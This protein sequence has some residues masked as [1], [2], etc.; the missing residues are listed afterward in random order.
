MGAAEPSRQG[1]Q[2][3]QRLGPPQPGSKPHMMRRLCHRASH[4]ASSDR[5][6]A[7]PP[8][9]INGVMGGGWALPG[10]AARPANAAASGRGRGPASQPP[11]GHG[12]FRLLPPPLHRAANSRISAGHPRRL[13]GG[14]AGSWARPSRAASPANAT[15]SG[16]RRGPAAQP[17]ARRAIPTALSPQP[18]PSENSCHPPRLPGGGMARAW[19]RPSRAARPANASASGRRRGPTT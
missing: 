18:E 8:R 16:R 15:A 3:R 10:R 19:A 6:S 17:H 12:Q 7:H 1:D 2:G 5:E 13:N 4:P 14:T 9:L 11:H